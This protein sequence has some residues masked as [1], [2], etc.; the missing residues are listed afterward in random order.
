MSV[1]ILPT[2]TVTFLFTDIEG[3]TRLWSEHPAAMGEAL[4]RHDKLV[5][6][7]IEEHGGVVFKTVGDAFCSAFHTAPD[8]LQAA[9]EAQKRL[10]A[11]SWPNDLELRSR[12]ALHTGAAEI[13]DNDYFGQVLNRVSRLLAIAHG[14]QVLLSAAAFDLC[15]DELPSGASLKDMG[16]HRL[17]DLGRAEDVWQLCHPQLEEAFPPLRSL[18]NPERPNNLP[19][20]TT[21]FVGREEVLGR[22]K[23]L[24]GEHRLL[25]LAGSGGV[26]K[27]RL[28][29]QLAADELENFPDGTW[30]VELAP[31]ADPALVSQTV[32]AALGIKEGQGPILQTLVERLREQELLIVLDN[33]EHVLD[34]AAM[35]A[36]AVLRGCPRVRI[37][38]TSREPLNVAGEQTYRLPSLTVPSRDLACTPESLSEFE[39]VRLFIDRAMLARADFEVTN[40]NAPAVASI[41]A[42]LDGIPL[43]L[44]LAAAR[45]RALPVEDLEKRLDQR[46][47]VL[48]G[49]SRTALPRQQ[50]LRNMID[51]SYELL[52]EP[53]R[54]LWR[55]L[56][57]FSGGCT[58]LAAEAVCS[59]KPIESWEVFDLLSSL[60][61]KSLV[62]F[63]TSQHAPRYAMLESIRQYGLEKLSD[64]EVDRVRDRHLDFFEELL[65]AA[66]VP[67]KD[68]RFADE[69]GLELDNI[70][71]ALAW[72]LTS[73][74]RSVKGLAAA[75]VM[76]NYWDDAGL[77]TEG[78]EQLRRVIAV[79]GH[80]SLEDRL[81][82]LYEQ[83]RLA[84]RQ[85]DVPE[86]Q[87]L[88]SELAAEAAGSTDEYLNLLLKFSESF[89]LYLT[90]QTERCYENFC[91]ALPLAR[92][93]GKW[94]IEANTLTAMALVLPHDRSEERRELTERALT[95]ARE[96]GARSLEMMLLNNLAV[97]HYVEGDYKGGLDILLE[98]WQRLG[99]REAIN[100]VYIGIN[101]AKALWRLGRPIEG[102][103]YAFV[104]LDTVRR[105]RNAA[106]AGEVLVVLGN[107]AVSL[108]RYAVGIQ[109]LAAAKSLFDSTGCTFDSLDL[110]EWNMGVAAS[111]SKLGDEVDSVLE[112][113]LLPR[114][115][116]AMSVAE[117]LRGLMAV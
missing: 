59:E 10:F 112:E 21:S 110:Q 35:L 23:A 58:L 68:R 42:R 103:E 71:S 101:A 19:Q 98:S 14:G 72:S 105:I 75:T 20:Q 7:A 90:N 37:V 28:S 6:D 73:P 95:V 27:S 36:E 99:P 60:V 34:S 116:D 93:F 113:W 57:V 82:A 78:R 86:L 5:R 88:H 13:R 3:S 80:L 61:D 114:W 70:R 24:L 83:L 108:E 32:A 38:A 30:F 76:G 87:R 2:G 89:H 117:T 39:A 51:W 109:I 53:E 81:E 92:K 17:K 104:A 16:E 77:I 96:H 85:A 52:P 8:A 55:R 100:R 106:L 12:M 47:H 102:L 48:T 66:Q 29:L 41:C 18:D 25:T 40:E 67:H 84:F 15:R 65:R 107:M 45:L 1:T 97:M 9:L 46:F 94:V 43:A 33:C 74:E 4:A 69:I 64:E 50:T 44:E 54:M 26:G 56:S 49:G 62:H 111:R 63:E 22:A 11:E 91:Y 115:E 31:V 79:N